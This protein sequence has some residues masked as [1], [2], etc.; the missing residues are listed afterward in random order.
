MAAVFLRLGGCAAG[1]GSP[2]NTLKTGREASFSLVL[3]LRALRMLL[4]DSYNDEF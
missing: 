4:A 1:A 2:C 3:A